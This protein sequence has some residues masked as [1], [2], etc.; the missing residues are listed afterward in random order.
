[1]WRFLSDGNTL[2]DAAATATSLNFIGFNAATLEPH[3]RQFNLIPIVTGCLFIL[4]GAVYA[5]TSPLMGKLCESGVG[6]ITISHHRV[7]LIHA[8][9]MTACFITLSHNVLVEDQ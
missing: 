9:L 2:L 3:L 5:I 7:N 1:L 8:S 4:T 6:H